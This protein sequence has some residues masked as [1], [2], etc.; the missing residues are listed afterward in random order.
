MTATRPKPA[1]PKAVNP[2]QSLLRYLPSEIRAWWPTRPKLGRP[3]TRKAK[4]DSTGRQDGPP[5]LRHNTQ[6]SASGE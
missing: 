3:R 1:P 6:P 2:D 4:L 5:R